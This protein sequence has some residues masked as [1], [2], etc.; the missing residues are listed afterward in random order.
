MEWTGGLLDFWFGIDP[1]KHWIVDPAFDADLRARYGR[2]WE[3]ERGRP[4]DV[5]LATPDD[6]L[7]AV[8]L[9]DQVPR[10]IFRGDRRS[11]ASD[12]KALGLA[13]AAIARGFDEALPEERR[14]FLYLPFEHSE[15]LAHQEQ[16]VRLMAT[17]GRA[18]QVDYAVKHRD[19]IARF[20]RFPHRNE[21]LGRESTED[22]IAFGL[23]PAW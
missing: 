13:E 8:I 7:A 22:E 18:E 5:F 6:A 4:D 1:Q 3:S 9:F 23:D 11:F 12:A 10:N 20:G 21:L 19:V 16:C 2:L 17:L 14:L 15:K